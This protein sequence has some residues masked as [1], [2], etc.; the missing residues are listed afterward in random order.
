MGDRLGRTEQRRVVRAVEL[1]GRLPQADDLPARRLFRHLVGDQLKLQLLLEAALAAARSQASADA[2]LPTPMPS[3]RQSTQDSSNVTCLPEA[4]QM[5]G[6]ADAAA[7]GAYM[8]AAVEEWA[9]LPDLALGRACA[10]DGARLM[11]LSGLGAGQRLGRLKDWLWRV[12]ARSFHL[13]PQCV[14]VI[15]F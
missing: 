12:Q 1:L 6:V 13:L 5:D 7:A 8:A 3:S 15:W 9:A 10:V 14:T 4:K 11:A 2:A